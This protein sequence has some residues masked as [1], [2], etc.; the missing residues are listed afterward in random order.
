MLGV[1][2]TDKGQLMI[3]PIIFKEMLGLGANH[4]DLRVALDKLLV[5]STQLRRM[6]FAERSEEAA[7]ENQYDVFLAAKI[8]KPHG[9]IVE[10]TQREVR[11]RRVKLNFRHFFALAIWIA[12]SLDWWM[13]GLLD[14]WIVGLMECW[15]AHYSSYPKIQ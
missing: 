7:I 2:Q 14:W 10:I 6:L 11:R 15:D 1:G 8:G 5:L 9:F 12:G 4:D 3:G 13:V